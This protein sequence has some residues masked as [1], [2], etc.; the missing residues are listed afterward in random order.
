[1][2]ADGPWRREGHVCERG[3]MGGGARA[4]RAARLSSVLLA[5]W[6]RGTNLHGRSGHRR[7]VEGTSVLYVFSSETVTAKMPSA[8]ASPDN[9]WFVGATPVHII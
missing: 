8:C 9:R 7:A 4:A 2:S 5:L 1:M 6:L 3:V